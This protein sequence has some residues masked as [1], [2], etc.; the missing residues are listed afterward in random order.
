[1]E[2][3]GTTTTTTISSAADDFDEGAIPT[4]I[5]RA[6]LQEVLFYLASLGLGSEACGVDSDQTP[7]VAS[8]VHNFCI[9]IRAFMPR[10]FAA[11]IEATHVTHRV[12]FSLTD[13]PRQ[14]IRDGQ[15]EVARRWSVVQPDLDAVAVR[16][17]R[18]EIVEFLRQLK[19]SCGE[20]SVEP[21]GHAAIA[22]LLADGASENLLKHVRGVAIMDS[23]PPRPVERSSSCA[24]TLE[25]VVGRMR[26]PCVLDVKLGHVRFHPCTPKNKRDKIEAQEVHRLDSTVRQCGVRIC[27]A[28]HFSRDAASAMVKKTNV[29]KSWGHKTIVSREMLRNALH[30]F[31]SPMGGLDDCC[32]TAVEGSKL[33]MD[34]RGCAAKRL[35]QLLEVVDAHRHVLDDHVAL[36]SASILFAYDAS[37]WVDHVGTATLPP[38]SVYLIDFARCG[39]RDVNFSESQIKFR[40]SL[41]N[42]VELLS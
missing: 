22:S 24:I 39:R 38:V 41:L 19:D 13:V 37:F 29:S 17:F 16:E 11:H 36:V 20:D 9:A 40:D 21:C 30:M 25:N 23:V 35:R 6:P 18:Q 8:A 31:F 7:A 1:M 28:Q 15:D 27:G 3:R 42:L 34:A 10:L 2:D 12:T 5:K 14:L 32:T 26:Y 33:S 4:L